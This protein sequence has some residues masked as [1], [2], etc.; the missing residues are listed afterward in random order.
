M[1]VS[2]LPAREGASAGPQVLMGTWDDWFYTG[3]NGLELFDQFDRPV[4]VGP[5]MIHAAGAGGAWRTCRAARVRTER[6]RER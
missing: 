3:L 1:C 2:A 4:P 5:D 6:E